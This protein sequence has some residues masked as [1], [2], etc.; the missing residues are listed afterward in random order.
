MQA[1]SEITFV[2]DL[3]TKNQH[4]PEPLPVDEVQRIAA[5]AWKYKMDD[6]LLVP[7]CRTGFLD[8]QELT[9]LSANP[10][11]SVLLAYLRA[12]HSADHNFAVAARGIADSGALQM[13]RKT[14]NRAREF[15]IENQFI[16]QVKTGGWIAGKRQPHQFRF[17]RR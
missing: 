1:T 10:S 2:E 15:L 7:D 8:L 3:L 17:L 12:H 14:I 5:S 11:A 9:V 16:E 4:F 13:D 6:R